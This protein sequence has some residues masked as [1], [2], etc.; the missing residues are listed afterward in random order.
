MK[1]TL[2]AV[3]RNAAASGLT[4]A[5]QEKIRCGRHNPEISLTAKY[6]E[7]EQETE[8]N[9]RWDFMDARGLKKSSYR[10]ENRN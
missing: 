5:A 3:H 7:T 2:E 8:W 6:M 10:L 9:R 1:A 4:D